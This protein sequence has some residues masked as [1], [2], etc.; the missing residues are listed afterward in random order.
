MDNEQI[1]QFW[2]W[3]QEQIN[4]E[5]TEAEAVEAVDEMIQLERLA[6]TMD[7]IIK[8]MGVEGKGPRVAGE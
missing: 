6:T 1:A 2:D 4:H 7:W 5:L 3:V 8:V